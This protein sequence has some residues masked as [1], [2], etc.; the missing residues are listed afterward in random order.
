MQGHFLSDIE[1]SPEDRFYCID[2]VR[3]EFAEVT[4]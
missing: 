1:V 3:A 2:H 4:I